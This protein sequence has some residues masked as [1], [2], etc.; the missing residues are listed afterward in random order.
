MLLRNKEV[1]STDTTT[2]GSGRKPVRSTRCLSLDAM[3][4]AK[5]SASSEG[6]GGDSS[7]EEENFKL[8]GKETPDNSATGGERADSV[9]SQSV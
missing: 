6:R 7:A 5:R 9:E 3:P 2:I 8:N 1:T 4:D